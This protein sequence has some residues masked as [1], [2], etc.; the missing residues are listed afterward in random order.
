[1]MLTRRKA[2][3]VFVLSFGIVASI[4]CWMTK[5]TH[6]LDKTGKTAQWAKVRRENSLDHWDSDTLA[7]Y[8]DNYSGYDSAIMFYANWDTNSHQLAPYWNDIAVKL[9]AGT[10]QSKLIMVSVVMYSAVRVFTWTQPNT[11]WAHRS[12][13]RHFCR[14]SVRPY[15]SL[16]PH[17]FF[18]LLL[19][20][21]R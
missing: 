15:H 1:M 2:S 10:T 19:L 17:Y 11:L 9:D 21:C 8:L 5:N 18:F 13:S 20:L 7:Y 16:D 4:L 3:S 6:A 14:R 12:Q